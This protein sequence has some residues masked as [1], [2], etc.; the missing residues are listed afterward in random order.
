[1]ELKLVIFDVDG[2]LVDSQA[3][4]L[5]SMAGAFAAHGLAM[6]A[7]SEV[8]S[9]VGLSLPQAFLRLV[10][11]RPDLADSLTQAY[12]D[13]FAGLRM[14]GDAASQSPLFPGAAEVL[15]SL[16][17]QDEVLLGIATG[18]SKRGLDHLFELHGWHGLF[19]TVQVS[20]FHP[21][22]PHPAMVEACLAET[23]VAAE[24]AVMVGDTTYDMEMGRAAGV[25]TVGVDWGYH[26]ADALRGVPASAVIDRFEALHDVLE[27]CWRAA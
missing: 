7:R 26:S 4:I 13:T 3:H 17:A 12:K 20:D 8:L 10:P 18:K 25:H 27:A 6:P 16:A 1:M 23:G 11:D 22:K 15:A 2:T 21:S 19:Q 5:A 24:C 14:A 9:I